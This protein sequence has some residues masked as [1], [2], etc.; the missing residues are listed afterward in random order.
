VGREQQPAVA[1]EAWTMD[2]HRV[3]LKPILRRVWARRGKRPIVAVRPRY[4]WLWVYS[5]VRPSTG[6][7]WWLV[8]P[9]V[10]VA[11]MST[12]LAEFA[13]AVGAGAEK[14]VVLV[15]D[16]A[17]W[18]LSGKVVIPEGITLVFLPARSPE[19]QPAE[20][21]W[22]LTDEVV[23]NRV[24]ATRDELEAALVARC[25]W[26]REQRADIRSRTCYHW[27]PRFA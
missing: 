14:R 12:A 2:E 18:H 23:A 5:F 8:L 11:A 21:L 3:G 26:L 25:R 24:F 6:E 13:T 15:L 1:V 20:R 16:R 19:L 17:G 27:W 7:S 4:Q 10:N 22:M 9:R